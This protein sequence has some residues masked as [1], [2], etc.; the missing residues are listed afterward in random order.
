MGYWVKASGG[1]NYTALCQA[2][3]RL[4]KQK[5]DQLSIIKTLAQ[6]DF[7]TLAI[8]INLESRN[9][10]GLKISRDLGITENFSSS[11]TA[12][13]NHKRRQAHTGM[14]KTKKKQN[15]KTKLNMGNFKT[16]DRMPTKIFCKYTF[17][18]DNWYL[19]WWT[20]YS[21]FVFLP[22]TWHTPEFTGAYVEMHPF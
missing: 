9:T 17:S 2:L 10:N 4:W 21:P 6:R 3:N 22:C 7:L 11:L 16:R 18:E 13:I 19:F 1:L 8:K 5:K 14:L 15:Q 20:S 12:H